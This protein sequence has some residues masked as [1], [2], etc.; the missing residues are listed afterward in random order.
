M[1][2]VV[3][4]V[5]F[6]PSARAPN[7]RRSGQKGILLGHVVPT[8][9]ASLSLQG[10]QACELPPQDHAIFIPPLAPAA[11]RCFVVI[12][13]PLPESSPSYTSGTSSYLPRSPWT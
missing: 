10:L 5:R 11:E 13:A 4:L 9:I 6:K 1:A 2:P 3:W 12:S 8:H 7:L